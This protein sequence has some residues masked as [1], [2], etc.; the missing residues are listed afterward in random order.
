MHIED[1]EWDDANIEHIAEH[2]VEPEEAEEVFYNSPL[3]RRGR[4]GR[5]IALGQTWAGRYLT[6]IFERRPSNVVR[7]VTARPMTRAE[8]RQYKRRGK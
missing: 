8:R 2:Q 6:V 7:V 1:F 5:Y 3:I 4:D